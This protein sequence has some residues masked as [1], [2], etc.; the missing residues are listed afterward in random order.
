MASKQILIVDDNDDCT[1]LIKFVLESETD[2]QIATA[3]HGKEAI[4]LA[5][6]IRPD[7]I[8]LDIVMPD[9]NGLD[10]YRL[11]KS[12]LTT[13]YI[14]I[15]FMTAMHPI[16]EILELQIKDSVKIITKPM[17]IDQLQYLIS[18]EIRNYSYII[19]D[20]V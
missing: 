18:E 10:V 1:A 13:C 8:L 7:A 12:A 19:R 6:Y 9:L 4:I 3:S 20:C 5:N 16:G 11:L 17:N 14:P 15:I 2:W